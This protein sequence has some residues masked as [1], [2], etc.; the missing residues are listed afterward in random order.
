MLSVLLFLTMVG[1]FIIFVGVSKDAEVFDAEI[2]R[3]LA[4]GTRLT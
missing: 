3:R 4:V 1:C 2:G